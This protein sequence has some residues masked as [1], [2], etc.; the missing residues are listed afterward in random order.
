MCYVGLYTLLLSYWRVDFFSCPYHLISLL[1]A[2]NFFSFIIIFRDSCHTYSLLLT[3]HHD[4]ALFSD[5]LMLWL[6]PQLLASQWAPITL[7]PS[8]PKWS[9]WILKTRPR[10][11]HLSKSGSSGH[12]PPWLFLT[13]SFPGSSNALTWGHWAVR[14]SRPRGSQNCT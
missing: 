11:I 9:F 7:I 12:Q 14:F 3:K 10:F 8:L 2:R 1:S 13:D 6:V 4:V 5:Y